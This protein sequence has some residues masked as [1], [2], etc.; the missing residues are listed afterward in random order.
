MCLV[1]LS[2][3][4]S[5]KKKSAWVDDP[6]PAKEKTNRNWTDDKGEEGDEKLSA[7]RTCVARKKK[8]MCHTQVDHGWEEKWSEFSR[9]G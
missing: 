2:I 1:G 9:K 7:K 8:S 3:L 6:D 4:P 5:Y